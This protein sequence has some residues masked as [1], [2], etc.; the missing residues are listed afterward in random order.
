MTGYG[1]GSAGSFQVEARSSNHK[2][3]DINL[4]VPFFLFSHD[5]EI[6]KIIKS[7]FNRGRI[8]VFVPKHETETLKLKVNKA[9]AT[10][11]YNAFI[12]LKDEFQ[13]SGDI[14]IELLASQKNILM[15]DEAET[16]ISEFYEAL[17]TA[18][19][20]LKKTRIEEGGNLINDI[21]DRI[22]SLRD[23]LNIIEGKREVMVSDMQQ[24]LRE[25][26]KEYLGGIELDETRL[27]Q[28]TAILVERADITEEIVRIKSHLKHFE[29]IF[30][31]GDTMGK[32]MDFF[33]QELRR[34]VN[35]IGSKSQDVE[36]TTTVVEMKHELEKI[37]EQVQ[38]LQ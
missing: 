15:L 3:L 17:N 38:N 26:L 13:V 31:S 27:I 32:K 22:R 28:E 2:N 6:R 18:L 25:R 12:A 29:E 7:E 23:Y 14:G 5:P 24:K 20:E 4:N 36:I 8:D 11:Y 10:E 1:K 16:D 35:T 33:I 19:G 21:R 9:L 34:E 30:L 37:K